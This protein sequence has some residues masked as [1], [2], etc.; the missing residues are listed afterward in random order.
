MEEYAR[1]KMIG[2]EDRLDV[3]QQTHS[4]LS[5][6]LVFIVDAVQSGTRLSS[7]IV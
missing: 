5:V 6:E 3:M 2:E 4:I 7:V 1:A